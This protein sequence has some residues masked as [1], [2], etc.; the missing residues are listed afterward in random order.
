[1]SGLWDNETC[2]TLIDAYE[3]KRVLWDSTYEEYYNRIKKEDAWR[4]FRRE[5]SKQKRSSKTGSGQHQAYVSKWFAFYRMKFLMDKSER[6][7]TR[8]SSNEN[9]TQDVLD[10][11]NGD[12]QGINDNDAS[13]EIRPAKQKSAKKKKIEYDNLMVMSAYELLKKT[14]DSDDPY[15]SYGLHIANELKKYNKGTLACVKHAINNIIFQAD[16]GNY[17][18]NV[19]CR[20]EYYNQPQQY[21]YTTSTSTVSSPPAPPSPTLEST[22]RQSLAE[23]ANADN[24]FTELESLLTCQNFFNI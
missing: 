5:R 13:S 14:A 22:N 17:S 3:S 2:L 21:G 24:Q 9:R 10:V 19:N 6:N 18:P 20:R 8:D 7:E 15:T 12:S 16:M 1:M 4:S 11:E 23:T